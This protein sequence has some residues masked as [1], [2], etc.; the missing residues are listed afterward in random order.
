MAVPAGRL[1]PWTEGD[2]MERPSYNLLRACYPDPYN[3][4]AEELWQ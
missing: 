1:L 4:P 3:V 2:V